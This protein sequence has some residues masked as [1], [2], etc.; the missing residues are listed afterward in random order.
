MNLKDKLKIFLYD[1]APNS[2]I[3][4]QIKFAFPDEK[5]E[6]IRSL[7]E[8]MVTEGFLERRVHVNDRAPNVQRVSYH[9][10]S[11]HLENYPIQTE[12]EIGTIKIPRMIDG[13]TCRAEDI[14]MPI[15]SFDR[16]VDQKVKELKE[17]YDN[18]LKR[19]LGTIISIF[20]LFFVLFSIV[21]I[22]IKPIYFSNELNLTQKQIF[23]QSLYNI[24]PLS[25]VLLIFLCVLY[26]IFR[27]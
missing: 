15:L 14:N 9:I 16:I 27:R 8:E 26:I 6:A 12:I 22:T 20:G 7:L 10:P 17:T 23:F 11:K 13:D 18:E 19:I 5:E 1:K 2:L 24:I 21:N 4:E 25:I 3:F